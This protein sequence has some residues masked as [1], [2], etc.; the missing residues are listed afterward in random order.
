[1]PFTFKLLFMLVNRGR[2]FQFINCMS[3]MSSTKNEINF[4][5]VSRVLNFGGG[6][7]IG[8]PTTVWDKERILEKLEALEAESNID[9]L[10]IQRLAIREK[11]VTVKGGGD[12]TLFMFKSI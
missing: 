7:L 10:M 8:M 3:P 2:T 4:R 9:L 11:K 1:M 5:D 6:A 12:Y